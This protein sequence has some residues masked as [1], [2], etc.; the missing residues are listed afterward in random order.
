MYRLKEQE[1]RVVV[2][3]ACVDLFFFSR[4]FLCDI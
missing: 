1:E 3:A 2:L 4:S